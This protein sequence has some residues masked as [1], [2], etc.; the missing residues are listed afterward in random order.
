MMAAQKATVGLATGGDAVRV[1][2]GI[3]NPEVKPTLAEAGIDKNL[4]TA[5]SV[6]SR[7][8]QGASL[9]ALDVERPQNNR[10]KPGTKLTH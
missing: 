5:F 1:A 6:F 3:Q 7:K 2:R 8:L 9:R 4:A 10:S